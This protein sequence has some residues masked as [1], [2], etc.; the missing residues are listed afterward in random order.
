VY[1]I[2]QYLRHAYRTATRAHSLGAAGLVVQGFKVPGK[3]RVLSPRGKVVLS[4]RVQ[5]NGEVTFE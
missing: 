3:F 1:T 5:A 4:G 2:Q